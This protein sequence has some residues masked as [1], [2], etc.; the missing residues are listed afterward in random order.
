VRARRILLGA[1]MV[2]AGLAAWFGGPRLLRSMGVFQVRRIDVVGIRYLA[3][4]QIANALGLAPGANI[5]DPVGPLERR[6]FAVRG[7]G[8]VSIGRRIPGTLVVTIDERRPVAL[9]SL[10]GTLALVDRQGR[11]LPYDPTRGVP[12]LPVA[13][14]D[15]AVLGVVER[16]REVDPDLFAAVVSAA[17]DRD[18]VVLVTGTHRLL[19]R[20]G[21]SPREIAGLGI[22]LSELEHRRLGVAE[23]DARFEGRVIVRG[24]PPT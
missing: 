21:A 8:R 24:A 10:A 9:V 4:E 14:A 13:V 11:E 7:V 1:A 12:D 23:V 5:F 17:R 15:T 16:V 19:F 18:A 22:V 20:A 6:V 3:V 2:A